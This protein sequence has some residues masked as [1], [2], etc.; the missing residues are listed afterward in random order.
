MFPFNMEIYIFIGD[1][2]LMILPQSNQKTYFKHPF[3]LHNET[4]FNF[5]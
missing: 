2:I 5:T 4:P 1:M 3:R